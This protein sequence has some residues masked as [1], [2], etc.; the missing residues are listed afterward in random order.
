[1]IPLLRLVQIIPGSPGDDLLLVLQVILK[2]LQKIQ[3]LR[4]VINQRKHDC[5]E[6]ILQLCVKEQFIQDNIRIR[7]PADV[8][9]DAH[10]LPA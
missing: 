9:A 5:A 4:F 8:N 3:N 10:S 7:I 6:R 1:M 2:H